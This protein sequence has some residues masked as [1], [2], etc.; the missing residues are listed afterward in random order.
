[1]QRALLLLR[2]GSR[3]AVNA[4]AAHQQQPWLNT[5]SS[6]FPSQRSSSLPGRLLLSSTAHS[7]PPPQPPASETV[8]FSRK[9]LKWYLGLG[10]AGTVAVSAYSAESDTLKLAW[11]VPTRLVRDC[12][13]ALT[14]IV[15]EWSGIA[16]PSARMHAPMALGR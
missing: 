6:K 11:D 7:T 2:V 5:I 3:H 15:G 14:M 13:V 8:A 10:T 9:Q 12:A 4:S 16:W 1:M